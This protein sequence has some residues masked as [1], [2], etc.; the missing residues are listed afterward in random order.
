MPI[1]G[2]LRTNEITNAGTGVVFNNRASTLVIDK[3]STWARFQ[4][5][6]PP[7]LEPLE[8]LSYSAVINCP[9]PPFFFTKSDGRR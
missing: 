3:R 6:D 1:D 2:V 7:K 4:Y 8:P 5:R 9:P